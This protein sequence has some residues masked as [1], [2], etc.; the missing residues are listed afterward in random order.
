MQWRPET[1][2]HALVDQKHGD[3]TEG[4]GDPEPGE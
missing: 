4:D 1:A 3:G 2:G